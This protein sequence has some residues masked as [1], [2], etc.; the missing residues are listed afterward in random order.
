FAFASHFA[1]RF[2][3]EAIDVYR[4]RF[5]PSEHLASPRV[6]LGY[7]VIAADTDEE[8]RVLATSL[9]QAF[10]NLRTGRPTRLPPPVPDYERQL[11]TAVRAMLDEVLSCSAIG[12]PDT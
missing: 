9:Q 11:P 7:N 3:M 10:V 5:K 1:P 8:A 6:M 12:S 2:L 4:Q